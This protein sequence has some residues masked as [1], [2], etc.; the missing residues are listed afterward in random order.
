MSGAEGS[1]HQKLRLAG[2]AAFGAMA[3]MRCGD[4]MLTTL[5][6]E[7][8][9][10]LGNVSLVVSGF[11]ISYGT[12]QLLYGPLGDRFG[13]LRVISI[14]AAGC[15]VASI[16]AAASLSFNMLVVARVLMGAAAAGI[17][18]LSMAWVGDNFEYAERQQTL[19]RLLS[20]TVGG[21]IA[22]QWI[23]AWLTAAAS[24]H[25]VFA[26]LAVLFGA[27]SLRLWRPAIEPP[28]SR[29]VSAISS[30]RTMVWLLGISKVRWVLSAATVEGMAMFGVLAFVPSILV[31][32]YGLTTAYAGIV[33]AFF[34][35]GG[36]I[37]SRVA[38]RLIGRLGERGLALAGGSLAGVAILT[39]S[40][41]GSWIATI[42]ACLGAGAGFYMLHTTLQ[43]QATQMAP[44]QRGMAVAWF[45]CLL[46]IGQ[47]IG[48]TLMGV[49]M[50]H[51][52]VR[53]ALTA[54]AVILAILGTIVSL[55]VAPRTNPST[56]KS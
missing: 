54:S 41:A 45:A 18:P 29:P 26:V 48:V 2:L 39:L 50:G 34:G 7:F 46:F 21:M 28:R 13:K 33:I 38:G 37:Y 51:G 10:P 4:P 49:A 43:T 3:S 32:N 42:P 6:D 20:A 8:N 11:A 55:S 25:F 14:A 5:S 52:L 1:S 12:M 16:L 44:E 17:I 9:Q 53:P 40:W 19:S 27:A 15:A 36:L 35:I 56:P 22:G 23:G 31:E 47:S 24:W 30:A